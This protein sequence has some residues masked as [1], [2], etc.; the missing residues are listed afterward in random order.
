LGYRDTRIPQTSYTLVPIHM[1]GRVT[2]VENCAVH[3]QLE[4]MERSSWGNVCSFISGEMGRKY[5][6]L[7]LFGMRS[8]EMLFVLGTD[9]EHQCK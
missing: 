2:A 6:H 4:E 8:L 3:S 5:K 7:Q 9:T 1:I